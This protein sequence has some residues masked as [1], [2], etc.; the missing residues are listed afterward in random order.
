MTEI[1][2]IDGKQYLVYAP[3]NGAWSHDVC[4]W[5]SL[6]SDKAKYCN[7]FVNPLPK[8]LQCGPDNVAYIRKTPT[9]LK[10]FVLRRLS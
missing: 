6:D 3:K 8:G 2:G 7:D 9:H 10:Q 5:C 1:T 4:K